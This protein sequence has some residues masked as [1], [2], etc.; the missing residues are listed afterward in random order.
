MSASPF[1]PP[2]HI[3]RIEVPGKLFATFNLLWTTSGM[4]PFV[5]QAHGRKDVRVKRINLP[6]ETHLVMLSEDDP[7]QIVDGQ[8]NPNGKILASMNMSAD[9]AD[10][11]VSTVGPS[12]LIAF[13]SEFV[14]TPAPSVRFHHWEIAFDERVRQEIASDEF[15]E[16]MRR[17]M[18][19]NQILRWVFNPET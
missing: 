12:W 5:C 1:A 6:P 14:R 7:L 2:A 4:S 9:F 8:P 15:R 17:E 3:P 10:I 11:E 13:P 18:R 19:P 16:R